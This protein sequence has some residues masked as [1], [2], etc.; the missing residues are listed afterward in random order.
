VFSM[1]TSPKKPKKK[2][3]RGDDIGNG[4]R[5]GAKGRGGKLDLGGGV[6]GKSPPE[7]WYTCGSNNEK[8]GATLIKR[9]I[10]KQGPSP[11]DPLAAGGR[12]RGKPEL[13]AGNQARTLVGT[14]HV[15]Y[16]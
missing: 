9:L 3:P 5:E 16:F 10:K 12:L 11:R 13:Y 14:L 7:T 2:D 1:K 8:F 6:E 4:P 15:S